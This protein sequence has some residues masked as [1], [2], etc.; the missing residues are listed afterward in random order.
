MTLVKKNKRDGLIN[1]TVLDKGTG[2]YELSLTPPSSGTY[3]VH[4][5]IDNEH[6]KNSP[7]IL[8]A[9]P[10]RDYRQLKEPVRVYK[11]KQQPSGICTSSDGTMYVTGTTAVYKYN[12][13]GS[14][15]ARIGIDEGTVK[16][17]PNNW[18]IA[19]KGDILYVAN[20]GVNK[21]IKLTTTGK[22]IRQFGQFLDIRG[23]T[24][25]EEGKIYVTDANDVHIFNSDET[26]LRT[27]KCGTVIKCLALD[28]S[29][30]MHITYRNEGCVA[31]CSQTGKY[32]R[33]YGK[34]QLLYPFGIAVDQEGYSLVSEYKYGGQLKIFSPEGKLIH[35]VGNLQCSSGVCIDNDSNIFVTSESDMKVYKF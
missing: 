22:L 33:H 6:I 34:G 13:D 30:S 16:F 8:Y 11:M 25:D 24:M 29:G 26:I 32:L 31:V 35:S 19:V 14:L 2:Q 5:T 12:K 17:K 1:G 20:N 23:V 15:I 4:V 7:F 18:S 10:Y 3:E 9:R 21:I 27:I 28:P